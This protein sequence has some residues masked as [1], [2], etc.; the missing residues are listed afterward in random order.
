VDLPALEFHNAILEG[1]Q[2]VIRTDPNVETG[3]ETGTAL[4][5]DDRTGRQ[6]LTAV[7]LYAQVLR[8]GIATVL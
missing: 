6:A 8:I 1:E 7:Y 5:D 3:V 2:R 4:A